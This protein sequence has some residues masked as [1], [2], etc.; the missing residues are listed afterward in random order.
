MDVE[1]EDKQ[2]LVRLPWPPP[3]EKD[4]LKA[5]GAR[6]D[7]E[8]K[9]WRVGISPSIVRWFLAHGVE[10]P[11]DV[12]GGLEENL[13]ASR[14]ADVDMVLPVPEGLEY[15]PFQKAGVAWALSHEGTLIGDDMGLGKTVEALGVV[16]AD[17]TVNS[18]LV[19][20]PLSVALNWKAEAE[21]WLTRE[22]SIGVAS[23]K[24]LPDTDVVIAHWGIISKHAEALRE[25]NWDLVVLDEAHYAK[26]PKA[27]RTKALFG[28]RTKRI[29]PLVA[30]RRLALSGTPIPNRPIEIYPVL[31]WLAPQD[32]PSWMTFALRYCNGH[33]TAYGFDS[34]GAS[35]LDEL[36]ERLRSSVMVRRL[37]KDVLTE[38]PE[39]TRQVITISADTSELKKALAA[40]RAKKAETD[41]A[42]VE[43]LAQVE[44]A[45]AGSEEEYKEAVNALREA[46]GVAFNE[47]SRVRHETAL[48]KVPQVLNHVKDVL[49]DEDQKL[50][51]FAHHRDVIN[52]LKEGL[53]NDSGEWRGVKTVSIMGGDSPDHRQDA[54]TSFQNDPS[55]RVFL[56]SIGAAREG[57]TLTAAD[58]A[59]F[60]EIDWVPGNLSQ[61]E[62]RCMAEGSLVLTPEGWMP[63]EK[64]NA[65]DHV[66]THTGAARC[67]SDV[68]SKG[69]RQEMAEVL[70]TGWPTALVSTSDHRYLLE[71]GQ[72]REARD[73]RPGDWLALPVN[74]VQDNLDNIP[75]GKIRTAQVFEG[76]WGWQRNGRLV[77]APAE[78][79]VTDDFL[80][81]VG[82]YL[83][84]GFASVAGDH[85]AF[86]SLAGHSV[87]K[88]AALNRCAEW[89]A[90]QGVKCGTPRRGSEFGVERRFYSRD[91][92]TWFAAQCGRACSEKH[93]PAF[94]L[95]MNARQSRALLTGL[96]AS[97]G[98]DRL[99]N[100]RVEYVTTAETLAAQVV[101]L[102]QRAGYRPTLTTGS[103]N[104]FVVAFGGTPGPRSGGRVISVLLRHPSKNAGMRERVYDLTVD[105]DE[106][107]IVGH[108][109]VHNCH[110]IGQRNAVTI[111]HVLL[112][113]SLDATMIQ[114]IISKQEV[115][116]KALDA[117]LGKI[118]D[119]PVLPSRPSSETT[120]D[121]SLVGGPQPAATRSA[122]QELIARRAEQMT[123]DDI[124]TVHI[125]LKELAL[126]DPDRAQGLNGQGFSRID[127][128]I[129]HNLAD[130]GT[131]SPKQAALGAML[132]AKYH[133]Q[134]GD[135][136][137]GIWRNLGERD[138]ES[139]KASVAENQE[140]LDLSNMQAVDKPKGMRL[141]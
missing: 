67:V 130:R 91:W 115:L 45:K 70:V 96:A 4:A 92:A 77:S 56:G 93:V 90:S 132:I 3:P 103:T 6:W 135:E 64:I 75:F 38:L 78:I 20:C 95:R 39:K 117:E 58:V 83:G 127:V 47:M 29:A 22:A 76:P 122:T 12:V 7:P 124:E 30:G 40:E 134:I 37:K 17:S 137:A 1:F 99:G 123:T 129:G 14:A 36:Q 25:R 121:E 59:I 60:A 24:E 101:I 54:V 57:I 63:I 141:R 118:S 97:D 10:V 136:T 89:F 87:K 104:Q 27:G 82:Y 34:T 43:A 111:Q 42:L 8:K 53:E 138:K 2:A 110:R 5:L 126:M 61:A 26:N 128:A 19:V 35:H 120:Q 13:A 51:L 65:G 84:D 98:Y 80:F 16:N 69:S 49:A 119:Q 94:A 106:S 9:V 28:D 79:P 108:T 113:E 18:V 72:W 125:A 107:F 33:N 23:S 46:Q 52:S 86:V 100:G 31:K 71:N 66:M 109:I 73:L 88:A 140:T 50:I 102:A 85:G 62:D 21:K 74:D 32:F 116:D 44:L 15:R 41:K 48:T 131:L 11:E 112:D 133:R 81:T 139:E 114:T 55:V 68:W 105:T